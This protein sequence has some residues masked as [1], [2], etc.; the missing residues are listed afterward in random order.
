MND[1][2]LKINSDKTNIIIF[3][4][5]TFLDKI[6]IS[7]IFTHTNFCIRFSENVNYLVVKFDQLLT[8]ES[9]IN[10]VVSSSY[11]ELKKISSVRKLLSL[12]QCEQLI[13]SFISSKLDYANS[14]Y[15]G[16]P[17]YL[18]QK[19]QRVQNAA[20]RVPIVNKMTEILKPLKS[21]KNGQF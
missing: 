13:H 9:H 1:H 12:P 18:I 14:L 6:D 19:L 4:T 5:K 2:F 8:F 21:P 11:Y 16:L 10:S 20:M 15:F 17:K 7:G 3:G